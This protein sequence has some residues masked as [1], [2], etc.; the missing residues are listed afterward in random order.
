[1]IPVSRTMGTWVRVACMHLGW[2]PVYVLFAEVL[3]HLRILG[4]I[5]YSIPHFAHVVIPGLF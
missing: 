4:S 5:W 1:M 3:I 2:P